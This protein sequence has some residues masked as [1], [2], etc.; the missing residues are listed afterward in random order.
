MS[1]SKYNL[2]ADKR[3]IFC[4]EITLIVIVVFVVITSFTME[5]ASMVILPT[6]KSTVVSSEKVTVVAPASL[7]PISNSPAAKTV[8]SNGR[9]KLVFNNFIIIVKRFLFLLH[10]LDCFDNLGVRPHIFPE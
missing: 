4:P 2:F 7:I 6:P 9:E 5:L 8:T 3:T 1:L 10:A